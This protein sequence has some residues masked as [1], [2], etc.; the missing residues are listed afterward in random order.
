M[1]ANS[2]EWSED[3]AGADLE[4]VFTARGLTKVYEMGEVEVRAL[5][6]TDLELRH[7]ELVVILGPGMG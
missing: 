4:V 7:G 2:A 5:Q 1:N 6:S 3:N